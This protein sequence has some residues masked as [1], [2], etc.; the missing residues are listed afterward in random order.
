MKTRLIASFAVVASLFTVACQGEGTAPE[1][2]RPAGAAAAAQGIVGYEV[3]S[4]QPLNVVLLDADGL[5]R[6]DFLV[7]GTAQAPIYT[8][9]DPRGHVYDLDF[10]DGVAFARDGVPISARNAR[11]PLDLLLA[12][13]D[14]D[15]LSSEAGGGPAAGLEQSQQALAARMKCTPNG[16]GTETCCTPKSCVTF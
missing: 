16:N 10:T 6:G 1:A 15:A 13:A 5:S 12:V 14:D 7:E 8:L 4:E 9:S 2:D 3:L 11:Q